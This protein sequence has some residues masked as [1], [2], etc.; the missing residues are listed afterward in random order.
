M[1]KIV[2]RAERRREIADA[3]LRLVAAGGVEAVSVRSV[4][5]EA[6][7][8]AGAVQKYFSTKEELFRFAL[9]LTGEFVEQRWTRID[10]T[11]NLLEV[12]IRLVGETLPLDEQRR[13]ESIVISAFTARAA[14]RPSWTDFVREGYDELHDMTVDFLD[15]AR[16]AGHIRTDLPTGQLA[17][18]VIALGD[19]F[20]HRMLTC[21]DPHALQAS[22][23][24]ALRELL[25]P[26]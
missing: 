18:V 5:A 14:V 26:R 17:D 3:L 24:L 13:A 9:D 19:G 15:T 25:T 11:G 6:G 12:L 21:E 4:A 16:D 2:D 22:L 20:A 1:P 8:S 7:V 23:T 10:Y